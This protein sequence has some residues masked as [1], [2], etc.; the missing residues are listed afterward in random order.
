MLRITSTVH[1]LNCLFLGNQ[2]K[3]ALNGSPVNAGAI[4]AFFGD[5]SV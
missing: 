3:I 2:I 1:F 4:F 5:E